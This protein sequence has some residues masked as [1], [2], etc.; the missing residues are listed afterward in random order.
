MFNKLRANPGMALG[1]ALFIVALIAVIVWIVRR[2]GKEKPKGDGELKFT[3]TGEKIVNK[4]NTTSNYANRYEYDLGDNLGD[5]VDFSVTLKTQSGWNE[6]DVTKVRIYRR[7][8][9]TGDDIISVEG[10]PYYEQ[11]GISNFKSYNIPI[12]GA[13]LTTSAVANTGGDNILI[14]VPI[15]SDGSVYESKD[16]ESGG[17]ATTTINIS[18][19]DLN[20][21]LTDSKSSAFT[22][23]ITVPAIGPSPDFLTDKVDIRKTKYIIRK[24]SGDTLVSMEPGTS[25]NTWKFKV[26]SV[27]NPYYI[28]ARASPD[29]SLITEF[30]IDKFGSKYRLYSANGNFLTWTT[31]PTDGNPFDLVQAS[32]LSEAQA[33]NSLLDIT[34][35]TSTMSVSRKYP[36]KPYPGPGNAP[37]PALNTVSWTVSGSDYGNGQYTATIDDSFT[38]WNPEAFDLEGLV[39]GYFKSET[40][41]LGVYH[42]SQSGNDVTFTLTMPQGIVLDRVELG[43]RSEDVAAGYANPTKYVIKGV[44]D[45][46]S[47]DVLITTTT[48]TASA[49]YEPWSIDIPDDKKNE[50]YKTFKVIFTSVSGKWS[51][52][53][54]I[55]FYGKENIT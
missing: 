38:G 3:I 4:V 6:S 51:V 29:S 13:D 2:G 10:N 30:L 52:I 41:N 43:N 15:K 36:P 44:R 19:A 27:S 34:P 23:V 40:G 39:D 55:L 14:L 31:K 33:E 12:L 25:V 17:L 50:K 16:A 1:A 37:G 5:N 18:K 48:A 26:H 45:D 42:T 20:Y 54:N 28:S 21:E 9:Q 7:K 47:E 24:L 22:W 11:S 53:G 46:A 8:T 32:K 49:D 35:S